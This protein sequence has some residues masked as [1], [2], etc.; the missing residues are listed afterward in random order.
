M[1]ERVVAEGVRESETE[2][3]RVILKPSPRTRLSSSC[4]TVSANYASAP[5]SLFLL[6]LPAC[7]RCCC[8]EGGAGRLP[9]LL[10]LLLLECDGM[11]RV[12]A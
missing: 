5:A 12:L 9:L 6:P 3:V 8:R 4:L 7:S 1:H 2:R 10:L 11:E